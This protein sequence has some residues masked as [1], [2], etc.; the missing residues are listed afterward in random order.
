MRLLQEFFDGNELQKQLVV[1]Y[2]IGR[3]IPESAFKFLKPSSS[4]E[5]TGVWASWCTFGKNYEPNNYN[6][7]YKDAVTVNPLFWNTRDDYAP[8]ELNK[9]GV[10]LKFTMVAQPVDAQKHGGILWI[11]KPNVKGKL[12]LKNK[13]WHRADMNL[14]YMNIR[15]NVALRLKTFLE[16]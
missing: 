14:F 3:A 6:T 2:L 1:A 11:S 13:N 5:E 8:R 9:G 7:Y 12:F 16:K 10:G 15:E 4:A